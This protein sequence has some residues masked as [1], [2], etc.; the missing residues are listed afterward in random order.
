MA[1]AGKQA[2]VHF[3]SVFTRGLNLQGQLGLSNSYGSVEDF[4][5]I[6]ELQHHDIE[7]IVAGDSQNLALVNQ[8]YQVLFWGWP[9]CTRTTYRFIEMFERM[10]KL[11]RSVQRYTPFLRSGIDAPKVEATFE[12]P[13]KH[14]KLGTGY[15]TV[16]DE[17]KHIYSWGD[18]YA[19]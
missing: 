12:Y 18:N 2:S 15:I 5:P 7:T 19:G 11:I 10:P 1:S 3:R 16:V 8:R 6:P 14:I 13:V 4:S 17:K 9:L